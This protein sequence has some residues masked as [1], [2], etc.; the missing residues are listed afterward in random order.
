MISTRIQ[1]LKTV[2]ILFSFSSLGITYKLSCEN[3]LGLT[4]AFCTRLSSAS[5]QVTVS[6]WKE[7]T[8]TLQMLGGALFIAWA[9]FISVSREASVRGFTNP[10]PSLNA[11]F[12]NF[13]IENWGHVKQI[14]MTTIV[15]VIVLQTMISSHQLK[16]I[17]RCCI[18]IDKQLVHG[19][20]CWRK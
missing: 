4:W 10:K 6:K 14:F 18:N 3:K 5:S 8:V 11:I 2:D 7:T 16:I 12:K 13:M 19:F 20:F 9:C 1:V 17:N 15:L